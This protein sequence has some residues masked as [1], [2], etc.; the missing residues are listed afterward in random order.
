VRGTQLAAALAAAGLIVVLWGGYGRGWRW[1]GFEHNATLWDWL[2]LLALP[3][4][5]AAAPVWLRHRKAFGR[6]RTIVLGVALSAFAVLVVVGYAFDLRWTGFP[7]NELWDWLEL[8]VLPL[9]IVLVPVWLELSRG[10]RPHHVAAAACL[11]AALA[12]AVV[13][14]YAYSWHWTGFKGNT[15]FDWLNLFIA[16]LLLPLVVIPLVNAW[17]AAP[18]PDEPTVRPQSSGS[19]PSG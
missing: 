6:R 1:T 14:G 5:L 16:P 7:G 3:I 11:I 2:H 17:M 13:G 18:E 4:A 8:L 12:V 15:L 9:A 19:K 10:V